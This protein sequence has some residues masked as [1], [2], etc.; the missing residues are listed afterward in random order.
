V[1]AGQAAAAAATAAAVGHVARV[2][3]PAVRRPQ[4]SPTSAPSSPPSP[5]PSPSAQRSAAP[6][7]G[8]AHAGPEL[9]RGRADQESDRTSVV[10]RRRD[11][12]D[13]GR[14]RAKN[15]GHAAQA[16]IPTETRSGR[17]DL[18]AAAAAAPATA[19]FRVHEQRRQRRHPRRDGGSGGVV[20]GHDGATFEA[21]SA[22]P[23]PADVDNERRHADRLV[24]CVQRVQDDVSGRHRRSTAAPGDDAK[25]DAQ[26]DAGR[27]DVG[28]RQTS[29]AARPVRVH[30]G[31]AIATPAADCGATEID[32]REP[33]ERH[34]PQLVPARPYH[35][36]GAEGHQ[37][38]GRR[39]LH[40]RV[41]VDAVLRAQ[42]VAVRMPQLRG[43]N[44]QGP[45]RPGNVVRLRQ[46]HGQPGVLHHFQQGVPAGVQAGAHVQ[47][48]RPQQAALLAAPTARQEGLKHRQGPARVTTTP[49]T[50]YRRFTCTELIARI[51]LLRRHNIIVICF[52]YL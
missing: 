8:P 7:P 20:A 5:V 12:G 19:T 32:Q 27:G 48:P 44:Q 28:R 3:A 4:P 21:S 18:S 16:G 51:S 35:Q 14:Q 50:G 45:H 11:G 17:R 40:V 9:T 31:P 46:F 41:P 1:Q 34:D 42:P 2:D 13:G 38:A 30:V 22:A 6:S 49:V 24:G 29:L 36:V 43:R 37:S 25:A 33:V 26:A 47:V 10:G 39:V 52:K 15:R 23:A